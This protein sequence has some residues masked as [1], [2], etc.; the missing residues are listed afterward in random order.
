MAK[1]GSS[2]SNDRKIENM[3]KKLENVLNLIEKKAQSAG[4]KG[5]DI[6]E[7]LD[8]LSEARKALGS[9]RFKQ[10][11]M[12]IT[13]SKKILV[14]RIHTWKKKGKEKKAEERAAEDEK[15]EVIGETEEES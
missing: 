8:Q 14:E 9:N 3:K 2:P 13:S 6:R 7:I 1:K 10:A 15:K 4:Q 12:L 5:I 11:K